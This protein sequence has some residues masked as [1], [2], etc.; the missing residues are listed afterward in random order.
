MKFDKS[1]MFKYRVFG[2]ERVRNMPANVTVLD[3]TSMYVFSWADN[4]LGK[5]DI[6]K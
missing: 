3:D 1:G 4:Y 2:D 6:N 5:I